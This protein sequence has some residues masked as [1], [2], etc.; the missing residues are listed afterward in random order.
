MAKEGVVFNLACA[1]DLTGPVQINNLRV[2]EITSVAPIVGTLTGFTDNVA[3]ADWWTVSA[4]LV[5]SV[6]NGFKA[7][8]GVAN[9]TIGAAPATQATATVNLL[10]AAQGMTQ[11]FPFVTSSVLPGAANIGVD[12]LVIG[13]AAAAHFDITIDF[14]VAPGAATIPVYFVA[15]YSTA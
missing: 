11:F 4:G 15:F 3:A 14:A 5:T 2:G 1:K 8:M 7:V 13:G 10:T 6:A 12:N 9:L